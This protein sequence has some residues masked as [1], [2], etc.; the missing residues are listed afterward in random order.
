MEQLDTLLQL[1]TRLQDN[2]DIVYGRQLLLEQA[3]TSSGARLAL[4]FR[5]NEERQ[6]L[7]LLA[8]NGRR[9]RNVSGQQ[10]PNCI[11]PYGCF[12]SVSGMH[13]CL[14]IP[15]LHTDQRGLAEERAW[16]WPNGLVVVCAVGKDGILV[17]CFAPQ[18]QTKT[19]DSSTQS[20]V[21]DESTVRI[22]ASLLSGYL[23]D[24][25]TNLQAA[26]SPSSTRI[27]ASTPPFETAIERERER[28]ARDIHD[29]PAQ[30]I[31]SVL[32]RLEYIQRILIQKPQEALHEIGQARQ[33]LHEGLQDLRQ[34]ITTPVP[35]QLQHQSLTEALQTFQQDDGQLHIAVEIS[36]LTL[37]PAALENTVYR[38]VQEALNNVRKHAQAKRAI[39][40][41]RL[42]PGLLL[43][44]VSDD[45]KGFDSTAFL[46]YNAS[47]VEHLGLRAMRDR[48]REAGG[49]WEIHSTPGAGTTL[50]ARFPLVTRTAPDVPAT[51]ATSLTNRERDVLR[52]VIDG[53][54]NPAIAEQLSVSTET[55]KSHVHHIMQKM[56]A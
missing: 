51:S 38:F 52:L 5:L 21:I 32:H 42:L 55:V 13:D 17:L 8:R 14:Y 36:N 23:S 15:D 22:C 29:G 7:Q 39:V 10:S 4:L 24:E 31:A 41:V 49:S 30:Q 37:I 6:H 46:S 35:A 20:P 40:R 47:T 48:V 28:I 43:V 27:S 2:A 11:P 56:N 16:T 26:A 53:L 44:E 19:S 25:G 9:P 45:G 3:R 34:C 50:Q 54:T 18:K 33:N 1:I 12:G